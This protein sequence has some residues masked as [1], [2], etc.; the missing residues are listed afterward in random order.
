MK[1]LVLGVGC[2]LLFVSSVRGQSRDVTAANLMKMVD[3]ERAFAA[4]ALVVGWKQAFLEYFA[5]D[6]V[7]FDEGKAALAKDQFRASPDPQNITE[8]SLVLVSSKPSKRFPG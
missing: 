6:A 5:D 3:T 1:R 2:L 7:G 8:T 4:R